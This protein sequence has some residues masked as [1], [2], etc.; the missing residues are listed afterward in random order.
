M[1]GICPVS[2]A[3]AKN[4]TAIFKMFSIPTLHLLKDFWM[5]FVPPHDL[6]DGKSIPFLCPPRPKAVV[7]E[8]CGNGLKTLPVACPIQNDF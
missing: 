2:A 3:I 4:V 7:I 8:I 5:F 1:R 6:S